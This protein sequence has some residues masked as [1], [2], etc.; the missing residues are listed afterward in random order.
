MLLVLVVLVVRW[1]DLELRTQMFTVSI[2]IAW[3][4]FHALFRDNPWIARLHLPL[5]AIA[6]LGFGVLQGLVLPRWI[7]FTAKLLAALAVLDAVAVAV[8]NERRPPMGSVS[9]YVASY[10]EP[11]IEMMRAGHERALAA[12]VATGCRDLEILDSTPGCEYPLVWRAMQAGLTVRHFSQNDLKACLV[13]RSPD[14]EPP[15]GAAWVPLATEPPD[16]LVYRR[17]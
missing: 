4:I 17:R 14:V 1:R 10:Y 12:A 16:A 9:S 13:Y 15:P 11:H 7:L 6:P 8:Q 5:F 2:A 3:L